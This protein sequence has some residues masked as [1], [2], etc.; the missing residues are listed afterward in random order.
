MLITFKSNQTYEVIE[1]WNDELDTGVT[2][3]EDFVQGET[4]DVE[5]LNELF[6][7]AMLEVALPDGSFFAVDI[8]DIDIE[9]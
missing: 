8:D 5:L 7:G 6:N 3:Y 9:E 4:L 2:R 1:T